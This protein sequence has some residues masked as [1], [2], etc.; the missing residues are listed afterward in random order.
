MLLCFHG[1]NCFFSQFFQ[2]NS[3]DEV[4]RQLGEYVTFDATITKGEY[5]V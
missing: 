3:F 2:R 4:I 5:D 1:R